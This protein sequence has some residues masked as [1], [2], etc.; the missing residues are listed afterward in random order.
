LEIIEVGSVKE[1]PED[2]FYFRVSVP[3]RSNN[4]RPKWLI[5][6][7]A[8]ICVGVISWMAINYEG[9]D[10]A[11]NVLPPL[12]FTEVSQINPVPPSPTLIPSSTVVLPTIE[13][14]P[15]PIS[16]RDAPIGTIVFSAR[17]GSYSHL[18]FYVPGDPEPIQITNGDWDDRFPSVSPDGK[19][20]A[21]TSHQDGNWEIYLLDIQT[22]EIR[23]MTATLDYE[24]RPRWSPDGQ[25]ITYEAYYEG[26][27]DVWLMP[28]EGMDEPIRLTTHASEDLSPVWSL[29]SR[30]IVF[31]SNRDGN[32]EVYLADLDASVNRFKNI[33][34]TPNCNERDPV[35][36]KDGHYLAF[37]S[38][39]DGINQLMVMDFNDLEKEPWIVG[40]GIYPVWS[41]KGETITAIQ[42]QAWQSSLVG[43]SPNQSAIPPVAL[44]IKGLVYGV[45]WFPEGDLLKG[46]LS[47]GGASPSQWNY[48]V[49][50]ETPPSEGGRFSL[51]QLPGISVSRP[52][53]SDKANEAFVKLRE[54]A[55]LEVGWDFL[56]NLDYAFVGLND[57]LPPGYAYNDWLYTGRAFA[58]SE[59]IVKAG[60]VEVV[61]EDIAG[62]TYWRI[63]VRARFQDGSLGEPL[64]VT[65]WNFTP[66][67]GDDPDAYDSGGS[68]LETIPEGYYVDFTSLAADFGFIRQPAL[69]NWRTYYAGT[70]YG[71]F[72]LIDSLTWEEAMLE[73]YP[74]SVILTPTPFHTPTSTPTRTPWP[75]ATPWWIKWQTPTATATW[76]PIPTSTRLP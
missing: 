72:A 59:A 14:T 33:S 2:R 9:F 27:Y 13:N 25:W 28:I 7:L 44:V 42:E 54:K 11:A 73:L 3:K 34:N 15:S 29:D 51:I 38:R 71:E 8:V 1:R 57:A 17:K 60:W 50:I 70:R 41:P 66:R 19:Q 62:D 52:V 39:K 69:S 68:Y 63:F 31:I 16:V 20:I 35:F 43:Y 18:W 26:N 53:L 4:I 47:I 23:R 75:T 12:Q 36:T 58:I 40:Q 24:G 45:D 64:R 6:L 21:F 48:E 65:P 55:S 67:F 22:L 56:A 32:F 30:K 76:I 5:I 46:S 74:P 37:S 61:R 49:V 10:T